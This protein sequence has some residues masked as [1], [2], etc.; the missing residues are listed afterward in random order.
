MFVHYLMSNHKKNSFQWD[1]H[2]LHDFIKFE[3]RI[4]FI[5][6]MLKQLKKENLPDRTEL[7]KICLT[8]PLKS[9]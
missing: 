3:P 9:A 6:L 2:D 1:S 8:E 5:V 7:T 4:K